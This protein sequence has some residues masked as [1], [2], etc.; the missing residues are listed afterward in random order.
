MALLVAV[1]ERATG[2][3][4]QSFAQREL[5]DHLGI[6]PGTWRWVRDDAGHAHGSYGVSMVVGDFAR[7]GELLRRDGVW[8]GRRLLPGAYVREALTPSAANPCH[9]WLVFVNRE[10]GCTR[11]EDG[12]RITTN[13]RLL[14]R[15]P[16]DTWQFRGR[17]EQLVTVFPALG[18]MVV[19]TGTRG[20]DSR[21]PE[22]GG[23]WESDVGLQLLGAVRDTEPELTRAHGDLRVERRSP[24]DR[25]ERAGEALAPYFPPPLAPAGPPRARAVV[26]AQETRRVGR[27]RIVRVGVACPARAQIPCEGELE[28]EQARRPARFSLAPGTDGVVAVRLS[29]RLRRRTEVAARALAADPV[30]GVRSTLRLV[31]DP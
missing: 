26:L 5:L 22:D 16:A 18:I 8:E 2:E 31:L 10:R 3:D 20:G 1:L 15:L 29:Q 12:Y 17:Q 28:V 23:R 11:T 7:L 14:P 9:G 30:G 6:R 19:R 13:D 27:R 25:P 4:V 21:S 24:Y